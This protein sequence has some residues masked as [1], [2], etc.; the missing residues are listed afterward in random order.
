MTLPTEDM[1]EKEF[2]EM[3]N[4]DRTFIKVEMFDKGDDYGV[5]SAIHGSLKDIMIMLPDMVENILSSVAEENK[6]GAAFLAMQINEVVKEALDMGGS[7]S[8][9]AHIVNA[10]GMTPD[11]IADI[12][13]GIMKD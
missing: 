4:Q 9:E 8:K 13:K 1:I 5:N 7:G 6:M 2:Q 3:A 12:I 10:D 11:D